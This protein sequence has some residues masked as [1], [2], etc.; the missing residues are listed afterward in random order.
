MVQ[1]LCQGF[2]EKKFKNLATAPE[3]SYLPGKMVIE[4]AIE[5]SGPSVY[6][7][8]RPLSSDKFN[9]VKQ[10]FDHLLKLNII[11]PSSSPWFSTLHMVRKSDGIW[12]P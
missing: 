8:P 6:S 5:T 11:R 9:A 7:K 10:E 2:I 1:S 12:R 3:Y 4:H